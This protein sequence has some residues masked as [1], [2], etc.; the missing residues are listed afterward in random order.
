MVRIFVGNLSYELADRNLSAVFSRFGRVSSARVCRD[1]RTG[2]AQ[3]FG[4]VEMPDCGE[5][6]DAV[7]KLNGS[8]LDGERL[9]A[10][11]ILVDRPD[12]GRRAA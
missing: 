5:A 4:F 8:V 7:A 9:Y 6:A 11:I 2:L 12:R 1:A 3:G 10:R